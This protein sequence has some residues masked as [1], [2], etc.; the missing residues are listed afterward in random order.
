MININGKEYRNIQEQVEKNQEDI[1]ELKSSTVDAYSKTEA[2][3]KFSTK[4]YVNTELNKKQNT[5]TAGNNISISNDEI[6]VSSNPI[7]NNVVVDNDN[8]YSNPFQ[9]TVIQ[10]NTSGS[11]DDGYIK[12]NFSNPELYSYN[13]HLHGEYGNESSLKMQE[14]IQVHKS[15]YSNYPDGEYDKTYNLIDTLESHENSINNLASKALPTYGLGVEDLPE[16][17]TSFDLP[18]ATLIAAG[19]PILA[20]DYTGASDYIYK[21]NVVDIE[22]SSYFNIRGMFAMATD[23]VGGL[24]FYSTSNNGLQTSKAIYTIQ[25]YRTGGKEYTFNNARYRAK[26]NAYSIDPENITY[27]HDIIASTDGIVGISGNPDNEPINLTY[28]YMTVNNPQPNVRY[29]AQLAAPSTDGT[30]TLK[31]T[32]ANGVTTFSWVAENS[33]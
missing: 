1:A 2:D 26:L 27:V 16:G 24:R 25:S 28:T 15:G 14:D 19:L 6:S 33:N 32:I 4:V 21:D 22:T 23:T 30:Y 18:L 7:F 5:L 11:N 10:F 13:D 31:C 29:R 12:M 17:S 3:T 20:S 9:G 8:Y